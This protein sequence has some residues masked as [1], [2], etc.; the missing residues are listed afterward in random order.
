MSA[1]FR[2]D[3]SYLIVGG[4]GGIGRSICY[5]MAERGAKNIIV[6]SRS[7]NATNK[8]TPVVTELGRLGCNIKAVACDISHRDQLTKA[9]QECQEAMPAIRGVVQGA[10]VLQVGSHPFAHGCYVLHTHNRTRWWRK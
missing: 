6:L 10:M 7:A 4:L 1:R 5:W 8:V 2:A 9:L 3:A